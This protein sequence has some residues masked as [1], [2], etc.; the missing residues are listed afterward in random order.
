[1]SSRMV[2][3]PLLAPLCALFAGC[4]EGNETI[5]LERDGSGRLSATYRMP[6]LVMNNFGGAETLREH[7]LEAARGDP[8]VDLARVQHRSRRERVIFE[9]EGTF[10]SLENLVS[11]PQRRLRDPA[12]PD[13][14]VKSEA[15]FGESTLDIS[16]LSLTLHRSIDIAPVLPELVRKNPALLAD[17]T[18]HYTV[19][20]PVEAGQTNA[21][22]IS[23][24]RRRLEWRFRLRDHLDQ[25]MELHAQAPLPLP[26]WIWFAGGL[27]AALV[28][29]LLALA[30]RRV[31]SSSRSTA[32]RRP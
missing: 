8:H 12:R 16:P 30:V 4:I 22:T 14:P 31:I 10:D 21:T 5:W 20:L 29:V 6:A 18:V 11:F 27:L 17:S 15:L 9:F 2:R 25:P 23:P 13:V 32:S 28:L 19:H 7:L 24:D 1:M 3:F 26:W